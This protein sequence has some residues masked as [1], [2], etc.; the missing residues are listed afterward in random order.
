MKKK[1]KMNLALFVPTLESGGSERMAIN[2][3]ENINKFYNIK[4]ITLY[5]IGISYSTKV[6]VITVSKF[7]KSKSKS[8]IINFFKKLIALNFI[9]KKYNIHIILSFTNTTNNY[10]PFIHSNIIKIASSRGFNYLKNFH[11]KF[12]LIELM[13]INILFNSIDMMKFYKK[14][15]PSSNP[16]FLPNFLN[17]QQIDLKAKD[18]IDDS[19][20]ENLFRSNKILVCVGQFSHIKAQHNLIKI[21]NL[22]RE[23]I[24]NLKLLLIGHRG[25]LENETKSFARKSKFNK[26]IIF[27]GHTDN[28]FKYI[29]RSFLTVLTSMNEGFPNVILESMYLGIPV[30]TT[31]CLTGPAELLNQEGLY[32]DSQNYQLTKTGILCPVIYDDDPF[33]LIK[34]KKEH[35][36][37][38]NAIKFILNNSK[39]YNDLSKN[40]VHLAMNYSVYKVTPRY[41]DYLKKLTK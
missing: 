8:R 40:S 23:E 34:H 36:I 1:E 41:L 26:D 35:I 6:E 32:I 14:K 39:I 17:N 19:A 31:N 27:L 11:L 25:D 33:N 16:S 37:F 10:L 22:L 4:I 38:K 9:L 24:D 15:Y 2:V 13:G 29:S 12:R 21:F 7:I 3:S 5:D 20:I 30:V 28:P 18:N